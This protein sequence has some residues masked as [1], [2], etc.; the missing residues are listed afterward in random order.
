MRSPTF[1]KTLT[2]LTETGFRVFFCI[3]LLFAV[4][5]GLYNV[6]LSLGE[7]AVVLLLY[8]Y[9]HAGIQRRREE[10][11]HHIESMTSEVDAA[12]RRTMISSPL[13]IAI[14]RPDTDD[15]IWSN[16]RFLHLTGDRDNLFESKLSALVPALRT[17][18]LLDGQ[19]HCPD[20]VTV[21]DRQ[22]LVFGNLTNTG[23]ENDYL[24][25]TYWVDVTEYAD[26]AARFT[27]TRPVL[28][29][30]QIDN[31]EDL[32]RGLEDGPRSLLRSEINARITA[33]LEFS[34]GMLSRYEKDRY[35][36]YIES[37]QL[38]ELRLRKFSILEEIRKI[39]S[40][41]GVAATLSI[42]IGL[43]GENPRQL[44]HHASLALDMA[45]SRG[46]DQVVMKDRKNFSFIGGRS[47]ETERR[48]KV[49][50]RVMASALFEL[51]GSARQVIIM[52]HKFPD[53]DVLG[54][55][56]GV[57]AIVR[58]KGIPVRIVRAPA[59]YPAETQTRALAALPEYAGLFISPEEARHL[60]GPSTALVVV[61]TNRPEQTQVP[62][63]LGT[64]G[65]V[66]VI[67]HHRRAAS[68]IENPALAF[69]DPYA[70]S[71]S[72]LTTELVQYLLEPRHLKKHEAELLLS[73]IVLD[74]KSFS[75]RTGSRT[76]ETAAF[77]RKCGADIT[78][79]N[80]FFRNDL[81]STVAKYEIIRQ[82]KP[83]REGVVIAAASQKVGRAIAGQAAD[84]LLTI[85]G[86]SASFV[87]FPEENQL[88]LSARST[89][90]IN[91]Q[92]IAE[93]LGGGGNGATAGAQF[94]AQT[95][96]DVLSGL[97]NAID[98]YFDEGA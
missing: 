33:W 97:K 39:Q 55:S 20:P 93:M 86:V 11:L 6:W 56:V 52:G 44:F 42:G 70:S 80:R 95:A 94:P 69:H 5:S 35:F 51:L 23:G 43:D 71:A 28:A 40:P 34:N 77:L 59:P 25:T 58:R 3:C 67:D 92:V 57:Y 50:S 96:A 78:E 1:H 27:A 64:C 16:D 19:S 48:T 83:Y 72:E 24:A 36:L 8:L 88:C 62:E 68:Y 31:Y 81:N 91:V 46:G 85:D 53:L 13:P 66:I 22:Y 89:G 12:S 2:R 74:T 32:I 45:L 63:L 54:A 65:K 38:E 4:L 73:G 75:M 84:E 49:K 10:M 21:G 29:I 76:F 41:N 82:A 7:I 30:L 90:D 47:K 87:I 61:D 9:L 18:W 98:S 60:A 17:Q 14:F 15:I 26:T 37:K 79:V